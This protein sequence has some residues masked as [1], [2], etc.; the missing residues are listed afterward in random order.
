MMMLSALAATVR[1]YAD[2]KPDYTKGVFI[3]NEDWFGHQNSTINYLRPDGEWEYRV[4]QKENPGKEL[5]C[6]SQ[7]G[8]IYEGRMYIISKQE[9]DVAATVT[10]GRITVCDAETMAC[11]KQI[12]TIATDDEGRSVADGRAF[13]GVNPQKGYI[14]TSNGIYVFDL[15]AL[16]VTGLIPGT[17]A[18]GGG[19]YS[20]QCG[21]M[22][23][24]GDHVLAIHQKKGLL[25]IDAE[26]DTVVRVIGAPLEAGVQCGF[27]SIVQAKDSSLWISVTPDL[28]GRGATID[29]FFRLDYQTLDTTRIALPAGYGLPSSWYAWT[30]DAF[31][32][33]ARQNK[34][35][36]KKQGNGWFTHNEIV[37]YDIDK[38]ECSDFFDTQSIGWYMYCG[39]GFRLH[40]E[41]DEMYVSLYQDNLKQTYETV[42][43]SNTGEVLGVY[44]MIDNYWFPAMVIFLPQA[45]N[46]PTEPAEPTEPI[47]PTEPTEPGDT[48]A[49][50]AVAPSVLLSVYPNPTAE[51]VYIELSEPALLEVLAIDGRVVF[52]KEAGAGVQA[53]TLERRGLYILRVSA[54]G[55]VATGRVVRR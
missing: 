9:R 15:E 4:F 20:A 50:E 25:V 14:S 1:G 45:Q 48:T 54:G 28:S 32:A 2:E 12:E 17:D 18:E 7:Y 30:A 6:T 34:L 42:R 36:W 24:V 49:N 38:G 55:R 37:C 5:G 53:V 35:Y 13:V 47:D 19:L 46:G 29:Y 40:P 27:G 44:E 52:R 16:E 3:L 31:C 26:S 10:G 41:T 21:T 39:A 22:L 8:A 43:L 23:K 33:S 11:I 51:V